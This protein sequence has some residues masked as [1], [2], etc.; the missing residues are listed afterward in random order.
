M[1]HWLQPIVS[2]ITDMHNREAQKDLKAIYK[3]LLEQLATTG[4]I[5]TT[6]TMMDVLPTVSR[7]CLVF[8]KEDLDVT[9]AKV[10]YFI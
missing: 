4:F 9:M 8:Q 1:K 7:L 6:H 5:Y 2:L 10:F 3:G